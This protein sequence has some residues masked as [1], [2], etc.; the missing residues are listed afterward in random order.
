MIRRHLFISGRS[1]WWFVALIFFSLILISAPLYWFIVG[2]VATWLWLHW[3]RDVPTRDTHREGSE[4]WLAP[5]DGE[6]VRIGEE[7][8]PETGIKRVQIRLVIRPWNGWGLHLPAPMEMAFLKQYTGQSF[9]NGEL[10]AIPADQLEQTARTDLRLKTHFGTELRLTLIDSEIGRSPRLWMK[11]GDRGRG[12][13]CFGYYPFGGSLI[14]SV[15]Q[16]CDIL[17][18]E[19]EKIRAGETVLAVSR[20]PS[21]V[22]NGF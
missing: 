13:A 22:P 9:P 20:L 14:V 21:G 3:R 15:P 11:S 7:E 18:V 1:F 12:A 17:V 19:H 6:V 5:I 4:M 2:G 16:P 8:D 10:P